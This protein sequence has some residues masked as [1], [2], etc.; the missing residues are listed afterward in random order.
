V[1]AAVVVM[2]LAELH[3]LAVALV[4]HLAGQ[5][6]QQELQILAEAEAAGHL[7]ILLEVAVM[8]LLVL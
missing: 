6:E 2:E 3:L 7:E 1:A 4:R 5:L 8:V